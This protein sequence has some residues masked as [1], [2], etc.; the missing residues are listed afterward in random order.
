MA[1]S[2][3]GRYRCSAPVF[4]PCSTQVVADASAS[5]KGLPASVI[6]SQVNAAFLKRNSPEHGLS[7][8]FQTSGENSDSTVNTE[9]VVTR[10]ISFQFVPQTSEY[11][12][13]K[14]ELTRSN[15]CDTL[16]RLL[17]SPLNTTAGLKGS[18]RHT[19]ED[20]TNSALRCGG[21][22]G[23]DCLLMASETRFHL[24]WSEW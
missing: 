20:L 11:L 23:Q 6:P 8:R 16:E 18:K 4:S 12:E 5:D 17:I 10:L 2:R 14:A 21:S 15:T 1:R 9:H 19:E 3:A 24:W 22:G 13:I 7:A